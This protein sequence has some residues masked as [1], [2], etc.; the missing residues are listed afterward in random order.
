MLTASPFSMGLLTAALPPWHPAPEP[1]RVA[2]R[3]AMV[4]DGGLP[5]VALGYAIRMC[6]GVYSLVTGFSKVEEVHECVRV[7]REIRAGGKESE[8][9]VEEEE[10]VMRIFEESGFKDWSWAS[11]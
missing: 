5:N 4:G 10:R 7:W 1:L 3:A 8:G 6:G 9:R 2:A 11:P